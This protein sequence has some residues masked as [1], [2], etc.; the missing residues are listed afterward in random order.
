MRRINY[1]R[2]N[3]QRIVILSD[4][5]YH[6]SLRAQDDIHRFVRKAGI[7]WGLPCLFLL[8]NIYRNDIIKRN[9]N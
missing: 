3:Y 4:S 6:P 5:E 2:D 1:R 8:I 7:A 9:K